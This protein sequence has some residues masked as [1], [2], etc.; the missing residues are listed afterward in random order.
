M[1]HQ[2]FRECRSG[3]NER[4]RAKGGAHVSDETLDDLLG[5][6]FRLQE[7]SLQVAAEA[8][9][10]HR[11]WVD[12]QPG[13]YDPIVLG[14]ILRGQ[15]LDAATYVGIQ[16]ARAALLPALDARMAGLDA[17]LLPTVPVL[18]PR[19]DAVQSEEVFLRTNA[20]LLR[21]QFFIR[22]AISARRLALQKF[23]AEETKQAEQSP[24]PQPAPAAPVAADV[25]KSAGNLEW[26]GLDKESHLDRALRSLVDDENIQ[27]LEIFWRSVPVLKVD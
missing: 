3:A 23:G 20:L 22:G 14:R 6:P 18:A 4:G 17:L 16:Q 5:E 9:W 25:G 13:I 8:A 12:S 2:Q 15:T 26:L 7:R 24:A 10:I 19:I 11:L 27:M 1:R 21:E